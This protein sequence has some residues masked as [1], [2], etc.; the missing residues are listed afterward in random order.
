[1]MS[2]QQTGIFPVVIYVITTNTTGEDELD[3]L[4]VTVDEMYYLSADGPAHHHGVT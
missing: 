2:Y 4:H 3:R 1:M